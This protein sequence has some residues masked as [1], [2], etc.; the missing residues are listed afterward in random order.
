MKVNFETG[1]GH[2]GLRQPAAAVRKPQPAAGGVKPP[3]PAF[4]LPA[5][6]LAAGCFADSGS[7]LPHSTVHGRFYCVVTS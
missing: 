5:S 3:R 6:R 2:R 1:R 4:P 7:E